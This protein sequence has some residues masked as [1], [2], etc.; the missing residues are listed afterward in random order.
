MG[1][2]FRKSIYELAL[3]IYIFKAMLKS[4]TPVHENFRSCSKINIDAEISMNISA[5]I[6]KTIPW[7]R[8][9]D[10][11]PFLFKNPRSNVAA[12]ICLPEKVASSTWKS[13]FIKVKFFF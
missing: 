11:F 2:V 3:F 8:I 1:Y 12:L 13:L 9:I 6:V 7:N 10:G 5:M 4:V